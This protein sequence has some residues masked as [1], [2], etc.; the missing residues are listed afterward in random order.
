MKKK[1]ISIL[2]ITILS[3]IGLTSKAVFSKDTSM[4]RGTKRQT[5]LEEVNSK[6]V[7]NK[8]N[9]REHVF[10]KESSHTFFVG[11]SGC[12][13]SEV[14]LNEVD[15]NEANLRKADLSGAD[16]SIAYWFKAGLNL[17]RFSSLKRLTWKELKIYL[18]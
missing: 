17:H 2:G 1:A 3:V 5:N 16:L 15:L 10:N 12:N 4:R 14:D 18:L 9:Y 11:H 7:C 13:L 8:D 6:N